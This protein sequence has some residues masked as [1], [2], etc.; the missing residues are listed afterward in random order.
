MRIVINYDILDNNAKKLLQ[1]SEN[2][3]NYIGNISKI[4]KDISDDWKSDNY[5][6]FEKK[7]Y[8]L[9]NDINNDYNNMVRFAK[10]ISSVKEDFEADEKSAS[11]SVY[12]EFSDLELEE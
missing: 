2:Y 9:L 7:A 1:I 4:L 3:Q 12:N 5:K 11:S 10:I 8:S 6:I